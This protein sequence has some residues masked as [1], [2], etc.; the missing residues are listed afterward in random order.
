MIR[1]IFTFSLL[2]FTFLLYSPYNMPEEEVNSRGLREQ[3]ERKWEEV[4]KKVC[5][6]NTFCHFIFSHFLSFLIYS[7]LLHFF[8]LFNFG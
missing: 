2:D 1:N 7:F 3:K 6:Y 5:N 8:R 4:Q